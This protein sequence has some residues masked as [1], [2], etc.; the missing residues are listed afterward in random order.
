MTQYYK[1]TNYNKS[2]NPLITIITPVY[3]RKEILKRALKSVEAQTFKNFEYII[4]NDGSTENL[5]DIV[6]SFMNRVRFPVVYIRK[7][8]GGVHTA[9]NLAIKEANGKYI[10]MLDSDDE[11]FPHTLQRFID[12][13][14]TIPENEQQNYL[15]VACRCVDQNGVPVSDPYPHNLNDLP[16]EKSR[17]ANRKIHGEKFGMLNATILK[18]NLWPEPQ[19][20]TFVTENILWDKL[21]LKYKTFFI[22]DT[23]RIYHR[24]TE[25]SYTRP[26]KKTIQHIKNTR[27]NC[28]YRLNNPKIY[29]HGVKDYLKTI[30]RYSVLNNVC[31]LKNIY[32]NENTLTQ[33]Y[34]KIMELLIRI[35]A[36]F[37]ASI[38]IKKE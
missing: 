35:P 20:I 24:E 9:R 8:N 30:I 21:T 6:E 15:D 3:N 10:V 36:Y 2:T 22:N 11:I 37:M 17:S 4:V 29:I 34:D 13:W 14:N 32:D 28:M 33:H 12:V 1:K 7:A 18:E 38:Y 23:L 19:G 16:L 5:D 26:G 31:H 27:W 25:I